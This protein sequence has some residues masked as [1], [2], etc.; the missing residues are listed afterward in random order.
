MFKTKSCLNDINIS[1]LL[2]KLLGQHIS[3]PASDR[4]NHSGWK[5]GEIL[6]HQIRTKLESLL[7]V[8]TCLYKKH[9]FNG[10]ST[11]K[12]GITFG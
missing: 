9:K 5:S 1:G 11:L 3:L 12:P 6:Q 7:Y 10:F 2:P 4:G 8:I